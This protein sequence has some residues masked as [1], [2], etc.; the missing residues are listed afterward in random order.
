MRV[1]SLTNIS[2]NLLKR[3]NASGEMMQLNIDNEIVTT[4]DYIRERVT[5]FYDRLCNSNKPI[6]INDNSLDKIFEV[7]PMNEQAVHVPITLQELWAL[8]YPTRPTKPGPDGMSNTYLKKLWNILGPLI[9][10]A[11][12]YS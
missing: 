4:N 7:T 12:Q 2:Q 6:H 3:H 8:L 1:R 10:E 11:W 9:L 5:E